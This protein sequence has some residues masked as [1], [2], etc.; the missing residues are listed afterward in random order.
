MIFAT[1]FFEV[2][3]YFEAKIKKSKVGS[4]TGYVIYEIRLHYWT[5]DNGV[6]VVLV[7]ERAGGINVVA[8]RAVYSEP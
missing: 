2:S 6:G 8:S 4:L 1:R 3:F 7:G 5:P